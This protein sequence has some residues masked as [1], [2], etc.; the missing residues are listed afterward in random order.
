MKGY[1]DLISDTFIYGSGYSCSG[2]LL[3]CEETM[4]INSLKEFEDEFTEILENLLEYRL[5]E[6]ERKMKKDPEFDISDYY[7]NVLGEEHFYRFL[8]YKFDENE[9]YD[10]DNPTFECHIGESEFLINEL[11]GKQV[12]NYSPRNIW[13]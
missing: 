12:Y 6:I 9:N 3:D 10:L 1:V 13:W 2:S 8:F 11:S 7:D 4:E 5:E